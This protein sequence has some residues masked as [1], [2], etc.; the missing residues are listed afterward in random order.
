MIRAARY[1][2]VVAFLVVTIVVMAGFGSSS[3]TAG[4]SGEEQLKVALIADIG[5]LNDRSFNASAYRGLLQIE[6]EL[7]AKIRV[8]TSNSTV[9][10]VPNLAAAARQQYDLV[11]A[12]GFLMTE[13][14]GKVAKNFPETK[15]AIAD[16]SREMVPGPP[17]N[18]TGLVFKESDAG[19]LA[20]TLAALYIREHG[21]KPV[22]SAVG[23]Q[24]IPPVE[25]SIAG[26]EAGAKATNP[27]IKTIVNYSQDFVDQAKCKEIAINQIEHGSQV[28]FPF[29]GQCSLGALDSAK[30]MGVKAI[31]V[32]SD[33][34]YLGPHIL[35]SALKNVDTAVL[36]T[37]KSVSDD[38]FKA[39]VDVIFDVQNEGVGFGTYSPIAEQF[40]PQLKAI[41]AQLASGE[42]RSMP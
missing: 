28:V 41:E 8:L 11:I 24:R 3:E 29:A 2:L 33:Q 12:V 19:Y 38:T 37:A 10:Y 9:D 18:V 26:Y 23:G 25:N 7:G 13:A 39:G 36:E 21:L 22:I 32:D 5:G 6:E 17:P 14:V 15:F 34:L 42:I 31:G 30:R 4:D 16:V 1:L 27:D 20:G 35:N 40:A